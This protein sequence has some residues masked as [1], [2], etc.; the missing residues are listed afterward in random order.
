[1]ETQQFVAIVYFLGFLFLSI[2]TLTGLY[3]IKKSLF[4][5]EKDGSNK[6]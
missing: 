2:A 4:K 6:H 5:E 1:M 3:V